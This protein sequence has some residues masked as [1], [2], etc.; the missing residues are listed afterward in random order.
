MSEVNSKPNFSTSGLVIID[1]GYNKSVQIHD[2]EW[3]AKFWGTDSLRR[4]ESTVLAGVAEISECLGT[5]GNFKLEIKAQPEVARAKISKTMYFE[6]SLDAAEA[7][8]SFAW[9]I[10]EHGGYKWYLTTRRDDYAVWHAVVGEG[11]IAIVSSN[12]DGE[13]YMKREIAPRDSEWYEITAHRHSLGED[14]HAITT[15]SEAAAIAITL[16]SFLAVLG[17]RA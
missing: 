4:L 6:Y 11:D 1:D 9:E 2:R 15:F 14:K 7:A 12:K 16:P 17:S 5:G 13:F 8:E 3:K 10:K